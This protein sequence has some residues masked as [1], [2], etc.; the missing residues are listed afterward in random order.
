MEGRRINNVE[1]IEILDEVFATQ[2]VDY[3]VEQCRK[4]ELIYAKVQNAVEI[5]EDPQ[6]L[7]HDFFTDLHHPS[8][9]VPIV[10]SPV[11][12]IQNPAEVKGPSPEIGQN[13]EEILLEM[14]LSWE[15]IGALKEKTVIL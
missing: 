15:D 7:A 5:T 4:Y 2:P 9:Q 12:F 3:W 13:T 11:H 14:G 6:A 8:G 1:L 10:A